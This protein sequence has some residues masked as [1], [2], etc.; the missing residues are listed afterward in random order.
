M[1]HMF[2]QIEEENKRER[3]AMEVENAARRASDSS[4]ANVQNF[5]VEREGVRIPLSVVPQNKFISCQQALTIYPKNT[6]GKHVVIEPIQCFKIQ[7][8]HIILPR[9]WAHKEGWLPPSSL[10]SSSSPQQ[11][12]Q[13]KLFFQSHHPLRDCAY[14]NETIEGTDL[15]DDVTFMGNINERQKEPLRRSINALDKN[16]YCGVLTLPCG[17]GKTV[18]SLALLAQI[19]KRTVVVVHKEFL[20]NQWKE[21]IEQFI[22]NAKIGIIR[23]NK[24]I[25]PDADIIIAMLQTLCARFQN[26]QQC[27]TMR[28]ALSSYGLF[29][30]DEAHHMAARS[31]SELFFNIRPKRIL[32]LTAT[33]NRKDGCSKILHMHMGDFAFQLNETIT[34]IIEVKRINIGDS[35]NA[36][37]DYREISQAE[38]Q[39]IKTKLTEDQNRNRRI[40]QVCSY[41]IDQ[42]RNVLCLSDRLQHLFGLQQSFK[43]LR[44]DVE[45][46]LY[47]GGQK[48]SERQHSEE[49]CKMLFGTFAMAQEGLDVPRLDSLILASPVT[50]ITQAV[51][52]I[53]R[54]CLTKKSPVVIDVCDHSCLQFVRQNRS[55]NSFF[56]RNHCVINDYVESPE[57]ARPRLS[58]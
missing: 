23:G 19:K 35:A 9:A 14:C 31:F 52:R 8:S 44:P 58:S 46:G 32:G 26:E 53:L 15:A 54:P 51:G 43:R 41:L 40:L 16:P 28:N 45:S 39:K 17:F 2:K 27:V 48:R 50:D 29:I 12:Q 5:I 20:V 34:E 33:P 11:Q 7:G 25:N 21:R 38:I 3:A 49:N 30:I 37:K 10:Q 36:F 13:G 47:I 4:M 42:G 55:R 6:F 56:Q 1:I 57:S 24:K 22:P 18:V